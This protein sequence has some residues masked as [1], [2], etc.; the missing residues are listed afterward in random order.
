MATAAVNIVV[1]AEGDNVAVATTDIAAGDM[2]RSI[3]GVGVRAVE[4]VPQGHKIALRPIGAEEIVRRF[5]FPIGVATR[6]VAAGA[7]V[8]VHNIRSRYM[9][10]V[11]DHFE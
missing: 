6:S 7:H 2:A 8:H 4:P 9:T 11:E 10:N 5:A 3:A 1:L